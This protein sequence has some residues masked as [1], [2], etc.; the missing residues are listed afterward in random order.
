MEPLWR[1]AQLNQSYLSISEP[2][3]QSLPSSSG[4]TDPDWLHFVKTSQCD[5]NIYFWPWQT[6]CRNL[7]PIQPVCVVQWNTKF[8]FGLCSAHRHFNI[9]IIIHDN[10]RNK[11]SM[12]CWKKLRSK[13][14]YQR[15]VSCSRSHGGYWT[16]PDRK[17]MLLTNARLGCSFQTP[18]NC[19]PAP[20]QLLPS[21]QRRRSYLSALFLVFKKLLG[22]VYFHQQVLLGTRLNVISMNLFLSNLIHY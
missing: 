2:A 12:K 16:N 1:F 15:N 11:W 20:L 8:D 10:N 4:I 13:C 22:L 21:K 9:I 17:L 14:V 6:W 19:S 7:G 3:G 18:E 5:Q